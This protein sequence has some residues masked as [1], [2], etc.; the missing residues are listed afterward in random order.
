MMSAYDRRI[1]TEPNYGFDIWCEE[2]VD[3]FND[4]FYDAN[5]DWIIEYKGRCNNWFNKLIDKQPN[6]AAKIIER[7]FKIYKL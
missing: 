2:V 4:S 5:E 3:S 6:K 1:I 7:A